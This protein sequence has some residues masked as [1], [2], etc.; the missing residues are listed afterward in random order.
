MSPAKPFQ[1]SR[2]QIGWAKFRDVA[3]CSVLKNNLIVVDNL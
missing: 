2:E 3:I 1:K